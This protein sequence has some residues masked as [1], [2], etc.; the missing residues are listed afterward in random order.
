[1]T[2]FRSLACTVGGYIV[3]PAQVRLDGQWR[4][5]INQ[6][7]G[8]HPKIRDRVDLTL[9]CIR[10]HYEGVASPLTAALASYSDFFD[11]FG[12]FAGYVD[13]FLL[14]DLVEDGRDAVRFFTDFDDFAGSPLPAGSVAEYH[15][16]MARS[17][18]FVRA[19]NERIAAYASRTLHAHD[20][21]GS[22]MQDRIRAGTGALPHVSGCGVHT[23]LG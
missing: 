2:S 7:R 19:R 3:F 16:Y 15:E 23:P 6:S 18:D 10:R 22:P 12:H 5:S 17:V 4:R 20:C 1:M 13:H 8:L 21:T 14:D 9:E 11:L